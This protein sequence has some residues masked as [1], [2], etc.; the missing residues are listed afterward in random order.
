MSKGLLPPVLF[1]GRDVGWRNWPA[2]RQALTQST[3]EYSKYPVPVVVAGSVSFSRMVVK[4]LGCSSLREHPHPIVKLL[5]GRC[6]LRTT[7]GE[8]WIELA[9]QRS[10]TRHALAIFSLHRAS[11]RHAPSRKMSSYSSWGED[12]TLMLP[13]SD[14]VGSCARSEAGS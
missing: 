3:T 13:R 6:E 12:Q 7:Y 10:T 4:Y 14:D 1:G 8:L 2:R 9:G 5:D 11:H